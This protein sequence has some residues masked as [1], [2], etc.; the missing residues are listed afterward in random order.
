MEAENPDDRRRAINALSEDG[1]L[2]DPT[3]M[4]A[5]SLIVRTD[6]SAMVRR[7]AARALGQ[8]KSIEAGEILLLVLAPREGQPVVFPTSGAIRRSCLEGLQQLVIDGV[9]PA[10]WP[11][12]IKVANIYLSEDATR[13][14]RIAAAQLLGSITQPETLE[15]LIAGLEQ[16]DFA[17]VHS[18]ENSLIR[19]TGVTHHHQPQE[20]REWLAQSENPFAHAGETPA[21]LPKP[22]RSGW[23]W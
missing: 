13:E 16:P 7:T 6:Q 18:C 15:A 8:S 14:V 2:S 23:W 5:I 11:E 9:D 4:K 1:E 3:V 19:L 17:V 12:L 21:D 22:K 10:S 20:W